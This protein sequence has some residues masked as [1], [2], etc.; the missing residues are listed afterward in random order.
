MAFLS[1]LR[2]LQNQLRCAPAQD[3]AGLTRSYM[4]DQM[5]RPAVIL[6]AI[7]AL[8]V[9]FSSCVVSVR[10][11]SDVIQILLGQSRQIRSAVKRH[12]VSQRARRKKRLVQSD[13]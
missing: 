9:S 5:I 4:P 10:I 2:Q 7:P 6:L 3:I 1:Y 11:Q 13:K 12:R 8:K